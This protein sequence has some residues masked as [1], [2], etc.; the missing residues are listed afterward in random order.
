ML[1]VVKKGLIPSLE[2]LLFNMII[3][4]ALCIH[5]F[6]LSLKFQW[7]AQSKPRHVPAAECGCCL[8]VS[9]FEDWIGFYVVRLKKSLLP[10]SGILAGGTLLSTR[11]VA[12]FLGGT[13]ALASLAPSGLEKKPSWN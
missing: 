2:F 12:C 11:C 13:K 7:N 3:I 1:G 4:A 6:F 5:F 9:W 8:C 10:G